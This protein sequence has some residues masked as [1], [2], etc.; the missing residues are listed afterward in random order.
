M[1]H[2]TE[3]E[4]RNLGQEILDLLVVKT[5][6]QADSLARA[7]ANMSL[8]DP[9]SYPD[10]YEI[11]PQEIEAY[12]RRTYG[13]IPDTFA[14]FAEP[15]PESFEDAIS[16]C[17]AA[18]M[19]LKPGPQDL[20]GVV[21]G[22]V[23]P[24]GGIWPDPNIALDAAARYPTT[25]GERID[26]VINDVDDWTGDAATA[27]HDHYMIQFPDS[28]A[29]QHA[30]VAT[31]AVTLEAN[32]RIF[33]CAGTDILEIGAKTKEALRHVTDKDPAGYAVAFTVLAAVATVVSAGT[34]APVWAMLWAA[35]AV[36]FS[37]AADVISSQSDRPEPEPAIEG[38]TTQ[39]IM[40][41]MMERIVDLRQY[42]Q[43]EETKLVR[44]L[45]AVQ[46]NYDHPSVRAEIE[47]PLPDSFTNLDTS[48]YDEV[49]EEFTYG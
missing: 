7:S 35:V 3:A 40:S 49:R 2:P 26:A 38:A 48:S 4:L 12:V 19:A 17:V 13:F 28:L 44:C 15:R 11:K 27:F 14:S 39:D 32:R 41:S 16:Q 47:L 29:Y 34:A 31:L 22:N 33:E 43:Q 18:A 1:A 23:Q 21:P 9:A 24:G 45:E 8:E 36:T 42:I 10:P 25:A 30:A 5:I 46:S 6:E 37:G 20:A